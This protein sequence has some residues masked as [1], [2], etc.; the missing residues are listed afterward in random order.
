MFFWQ[1]TDGRRIQFEDA[2]KHIYHCQYRNK[3]ATLTS[4]KGALGLR[5]QNGLALL[6]ELEKKKTV[7]IS[8]E[9]IEL[10][11][12][13]KAWALQV[14]RAH[15]LWESHLCD[16]IGLPLEDIHRQAEI[17][18]HQLTEEE[19][20]RL[21]EKL[22]FPVR[23]PHGDPIPTSAHKMD[24]SPATCIL[25]WPVG[26]M[27]RI[28]HIEDEPPSVFTQILSEGL[29]LDTFVKVL[30]SNEN[31]L[32][33]WTN[34]HDCWIAPIIGANI[35]VDEA[36]EWVKEEAAIALTSIPKGEKAKILFI[37]AQGLTRRR[38]MDLG[39]VPGTVIQSVMPSAFK[40]PLAYLVRGTLIALRR[41]QSNQIIVQKVEK[42][43]DDSS[44][45]R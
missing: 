41:E 12:S 23:D 27:A 40:E 10:T 45:T 4:L 44:K 11:P 7:R 6:E 33:L 35:F 37:K 8:G 9:G 34:L 16:D 14:I 32:R 29:L 38:F 1:K 30:Q 20:N 2:L 19:V 43:D 15:R 26:K 22:G 21:E 42:E 28:V 36:P 5:A 17:K 3:P 31:G 24:K 13:G 25:D 18:E 39:L